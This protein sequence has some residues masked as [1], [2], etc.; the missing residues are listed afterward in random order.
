[1]GSGDEQVL[2][3]R[4]AKKE[5]PRA[6]HGGGSFRVCDREAAER[7]SSNSRRPALLNHSALQ[8]AEL[9]DG[10]EA[11]AEA[12]ADSTATNTGDPSSQTYSAT[13]PTV[14][15][16]PAAP[17]PR[18]GDKPTALPTGADKS[19]VT[20][21]AIS[22]PSGSGTIKGMDESFSAQLST[23]I[24][25]FTVPIAL[26]AARGGAQ[27]SLSLSYSS[28]GGLGV[29]GMGWSLDVPF[30]ARQ[31]DRGIPKYQD[32]GTWHP[33]QDRFVFNGGQELVPICTVG[34]GGIC[35]GKLTGEEFPDW[36]TG[37]QYFRARVEGSFLR[38]FW[39][40]DGLSW[41]VQ[42]K[43]GVTME[44]GVPR[45]GSNY[46]GALER[47]PDKAS[48]IYRW[49]LVRQYDPHGLPKPGG[50]P[51]VNVVVYRYIQDGGMAYLSEIFDTPPA[52]APTTEG[53]STYAHH[54]TITYDTRTDPTESYRAGWRIQQN[55][56]VARLEVA[57]KTFNGGVQAERRRVRR[58]HFDYEAG[59]HASLLASVQVEGRCTASEDDAPVEGQ[60]TSCPRLP[61]MVFG[62]SHVDAFDTTGAPGFSDLSGFEGFDERIRKMKTSPTNSL[63]EELSDLFDVNGDAL[64]DVL[65]TA[66]GS[67]GGKHG[68]FFNAPGG[69]A[70]AFDSAQTIS[71]A[72]VVGVDVNVLSLKNTNVN[73]LDVDGDGIVELLHMP[74]VKTY[75]VYSPLF[76][77][78]G[79]KWQGREVSLASNLNPKIDFST[80]AVD[81]RTLDVNFDGLIDVVI[82]TGTQYQTFFGLGRYPGGDGWFGKATW[83]GATSASLSN[84]PTTACVPW[85][86]TP[87]QFSDPDIKL[88]DMNGDGI[89]DIVRVRK[90]DIRYW[91]GRGNGF[92]G[93]GKRDDCPGGTYGANRYVLMTSSPQ[94]SD[95]QGDSLLLD[96]V[97]G[98]GLSDLVQIRSTDRR[99]AKHRRRGLDEVAPHSRNAARSRVREASAAR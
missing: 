95:I 25:T 31:T 73:P 10:A 42:D 85:S 80:D 77:P 63:D 56:R 3:S 62:Y 69:V 88:G 94:Y 2:H 17:P 51:P 20:S 57:S 89:T 99:M 8:T 65:V 16:L 38:F 37:Y 1:M 41:I 28:G 71:V 78:Q 14:A 26:P 79:W 9:V 48:E 98:D 21:Q 55:L 24:A 34:L 84:L 92:W 60:A 72:G 11:N 96:D 76:G 87:V 4:C 6:A 66:P 33:E 19:G 29:A 75:S 30:I 15:P 50:T 52:T 27:P 64:P 39:S 22:V 97:N 74:A 91:P 83:T 47:N 46:L 90:G 7:A 45:D 13:P 81:I 54:T 86:A 61:A 93:T 53:L 49:H 18:T 23:G 68:V 43:T 32:F 44:L 58:Y 35:A 36:A 40:S 70:D 5:P 12:T 82:S 59:A 67:F